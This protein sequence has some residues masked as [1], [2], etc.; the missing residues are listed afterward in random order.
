MTIHSNPEI[1]PSHPVAPYQGPVMRKLLIPAL[2][3]AVMGA[4]CAAA[5]EGFNEGYNDGLNKSTEST[6]LD[7]TVTTLIEL[8][9][10]AEA[11][12]P[13]VTEAA[14]VTEG[15]APVESASQENAREMAA[16]YLDTMA[17][18]ASGLIEQ[19]EFEGFSQDDAAYGVFVAEADWNEQAAKSAA[20]YLDTMAFSRSGLID[21]LVFEGFTQE[22]ATYGVST[23]GL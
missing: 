3:L 2:L 15:P 7:D 16:S 10:S 6:V 11:A 20:K 23:T 4:S 22:Q 9:G 14:A 19:L 8:P 13:V 5:Q 12:A 17:F 1:P 21:Q 18:S